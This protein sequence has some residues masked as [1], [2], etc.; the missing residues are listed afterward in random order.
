MSGLAY[1]AFL[2]TEEIPGLAGDP[3]R[4][5]EARSEQNLAGFYYW[6]AGISQEGFTTPEAQQLVYATLKGLFPDKL[7]LYPTRLDPIV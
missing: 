6:D 7:V 2:T 3:A 5:A 1:L 4:V